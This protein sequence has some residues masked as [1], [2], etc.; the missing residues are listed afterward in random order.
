[1]QR[2]WGRGYIYSSNVPRVEDTQ[3]VGGCAKVQLK[4]VVCCLD[5]E[6]VQVSDDNYVLVC[7]ALEAHYKI[8]G[9]ALTQDETALLL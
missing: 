2:A 5:C 1:M 8:D 4:L 3:R 7:L 6:R 9:S